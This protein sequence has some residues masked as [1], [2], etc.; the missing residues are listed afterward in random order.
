[1]GFNR[2]REAFKHMP[3]QEQ[4]RAKLCSPG[5]AAVVVRNNDIVSLCGGCCIP[6][7]FVGALAT[8]GKELDEVTLL[9]GFAL[10]E[11]NYMDPGLKGHFNL[12]S[13][14]VGPMERKS[15]K[16]G[17]TSYVPAHLQQMGKWLENRR[18]N[19]VANA[20]SPPDERGY[21]SRSLFAGLSHKIAFDS[22]ENVIVEVNSQL[23]RLNGGALDIHVSEVDYIIENDYELTQIEDIPIS[24]TEKAIAGHVVELIP[25]GAT[26]QLG[27]GGLPNAVGY[28]LR[29][30]KNLGCHAEVVS[31]SIM[32]LMKV[33]AVNGSCK[34]FYPGKVL[35]C[36]CVGNKELW[37]FVH[38][39]TDFLF[40]E[41]D[42]INNPEII[43]RNDNLI[44]VNNSLMMDLTG[45]AASES[46]GPVQYS[47]TGGQVNF[48]H[49]AAR[50]QGGK[51]ILAFSST[52]SDNDGNLHSRIL[53][54]LSE[55]TVI[56]TSRND[57]QLVVT[58]FGI[59]DLRWK[60][61]RERVKALLKIAHPDF[62]DTLAFQARK[63]RW[64]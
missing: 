25:N 10:K 42:Y 13:V 4:Y 61:I 64:L 39:N 33:G 36:F 43:G 56:S 32:E 51:S 41:V 9:A 2:K 28:F 12:E 58:E 37:N 20:V 62:R 21:M 8:R 14:F 11:Y 63:Y 45:Q 1:M 50:S 35:G 54:V 26:V 19:V 16:E 34:N 46:I 17:I 59:A 3:W 38:E 55:G 23:P 7:G 44:S 31:N 30:K 6:D 40:Y 57:V 27:L 49:G 47:G 29:D 53:P 5:E 60:S 52:Y 48:V 22:A 15:I 24:A 18:P